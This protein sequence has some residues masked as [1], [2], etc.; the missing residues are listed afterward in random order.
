MTAL[1]ILVNGQPAE[2]IS[3]FDRGLQFGD[4]L[5]ETIACIAGDMPFMKQ[6]MRR[7]ATGC[8]RLAI[9]CPD[10]DLLVSEARRVAAGQS[11]AIIKIIVTR[12]TSQRGYAFEDV[13]AP[14]RIVVANP[15][16]TLPAGFWE[17]G[18]VLT[19]CLATL[20][21]Q[22]LLAGIKHL[23]RLEQ[24]LARAELNGK[25]AQEGLLCDTEGNVIEAT[26]HNLFLFRN[27]EF[28]TPSLA[29][30]GVEGIMRE[31]VLDW[32][33]SN[34]Y[35]IHIADIRIEDLLA[36]ESLFLCNSIHGIWPVRR[37]DETIYTVHN[38]IRELINRIAQ[39]LPYQ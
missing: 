22:P 16:P 23:N 13:M 12:G 38:T 28:V 36:A 37:F 18:V 26:A 25:D 30:A 21:Q 39:L 17:Q 31:Q 35:K 32:L 9:P 1:R 15:W 24:V 19:R 11:R 33:S 27:G 2:A 6:H 7:L 5:F 34:G 29:R 10:K 8:Q 14:N 20:A 3:V 4:G